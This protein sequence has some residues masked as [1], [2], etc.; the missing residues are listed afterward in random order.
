MV[1]YIVI[2]LFAWWAAIFIT[3]FK[4]NTVSILTKR[5]IP[6]EPK[7]FSASTKSV[8]EIIEN[9]AEDKELVKKLKKSLFYSRLSTILFF[10]WIS[11]VLLLLFLS[12][13]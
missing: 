2:I 9:H 13:E 3:S 4:I 8:R 12:H 10:S 5:N 1:K 7:G 11:M 6:F